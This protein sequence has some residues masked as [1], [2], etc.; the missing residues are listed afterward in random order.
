MA[1]SSS[2]FTCAE[3]D[4]EKPREVVGE[5]G[6]MSTEGRA[7]FVSIGRVAGRGKDKISSVCVGR[8]Y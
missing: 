2:R 4:V 7:I 8:S 1:Y 5:D 3:A 6:A